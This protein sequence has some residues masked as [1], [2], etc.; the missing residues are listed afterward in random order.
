MAFLFT[1][2]NI[3]GGKATVYSVHCNDDSR[4]SVHCEG[5]IYNLREQNGKYQF[6]DDNIPDWLKGHEE[7][8]DG[9]IKEYYKSNAPRG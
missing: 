7:E 1:V 3:G 9:K 6:A 8:I 4:H 5:G 2:H